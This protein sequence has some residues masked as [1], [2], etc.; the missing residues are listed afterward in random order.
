MLRLTS[1]PYKF[2]GRLEDK[3]MAREIP[4][5]GPC[6]SY[7][8]LEKC[9]HKFNTRGRDLFSASVQL[10]IWANGLLPSGDDGRTSE[11]LC[12]SGL[13]ETILKFEPMSYFIILQIGELSNSDGRC[14]RASTSAAGSSI[15]QLR[16]RK[17]I[18]GRKGGRRKGEQAGKAWDGMEQGVEG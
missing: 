8:G 4:R 11:A 15:G 18:Q 17:R 13:C 2:N 10:R 16:L 7:S 5:A 12:E 3:E 6:L 1:R 9:G 14:N